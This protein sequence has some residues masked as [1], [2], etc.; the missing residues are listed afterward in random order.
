MKNKRRLLFFGELPTDSIHGISISNMVNLKIL[1]SNFVIDIVEDKSR[2]TEHNRLTIRKIICFLVNNLELIYKLSFHRYKYFYLVFSLSS[3]GSFKSLSAVVCFRLLN[4]GKV[5]IHLH[6]GDFFKRFYKV[7]FNRLITSFVFRLSDKIIVLSESQKNEFER[8]FSRTFNILHNTV[9]M[10]YKKRN[11][12]KI[13][14]KFVFISNYLIDKGIID[15]LEVFNKLTQ[16]DD[17]VSLVT[18]GEFPDKELKEEI[19]SYSSARISINGPISG[20]KKFEAISQSDCLIL[21]SWNEGEP[22][23]LLEAMSLGIPVIA[24]KVGLIPELLGEEYPFMIIPA[25]RSSLEEVIIRFIHCDDIT[26][27]SK[28]LENRYINQYSKKMHTEE[29]NNIFV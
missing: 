6:R 13:D 21:P 20:E 26:D 5:I 11:H 29:L 14:K 2:L 27:I 23:V 24:S 25:S 15:L 1:E 18:Y 17:E 7:A 10:E 19:L 28:K 9:E 3:L 12:L 4:R 16:T 8:V 22:L